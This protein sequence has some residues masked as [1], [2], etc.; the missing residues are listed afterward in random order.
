MAAFHRH[1]NQNQLRFK[2]S[3]FV[4]TIML[5]LLLLRLF[6]LQVIFGDYYRQKSE[7]NRLRIVTLNPPRGKITDRFGEIL[8]DVRPAF[9]LEISKGRHESITP[10]LELLARLLKLPVEKLKAQLVKY[11]YRRSPYQPQ[12]LLKDIS[13]DQL[14]LVE[15][16]L[17]F[18]PGVQIG[19]QPARIYTHASLA[20]Q[21][22]GYLREINSDQLKLPEYEDS[23]PGDMIGQTGLEKIFEDELSGTKGQQGV[24]VD[25][26]GQK[27]S[28]A[29]HLA[30]QRGRDLTLSLDFNLQKTAETALAGK[31]GA[32]VAV[33][34]Y[35]G[36][37]LALVSA[38]SS[39]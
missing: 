18:L 4:A 37:I 22:I 14:A 26:R 19:T 12:L 21:V 28:E 20:S 36:E 13:R 25:A 16:N 15:A 1:S 2:I 11:Q 29:F 30:A 7:N 38:S 8:A 39:S 27:V 23:R 10:Q 34:P 35:N 5:A 32:L 33:N 17:H 31:R 3:F 6:F 9:N 24:F